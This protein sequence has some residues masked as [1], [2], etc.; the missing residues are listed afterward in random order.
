M[1]YLSGFTGVLANLR[2]YLYIPKWAFH[3][4]KDE[5]VLLNLWRGC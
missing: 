1:Q 4:A 3:G 2:Y 5:V